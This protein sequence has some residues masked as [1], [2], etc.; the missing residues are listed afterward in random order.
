[1]RGFLKVV[2]AS[3][4][5]LVSSKIQASGL[6]LE[7]VK[8]GTANIEGCRWAEGAEEPLDVSLYY[9]VPAMNN[10]VTHPDIV[11]FQDYFGPL[12]GQ[13]TI[14]V[15]SAGGFDTIIV[16]EMS[17]RWKYWLVF[18]PYA[19][20]DGSME[21]PVFRVSN[22]KEGGWERPY[23]FGYRYI[24]SI[25]VFDTVWIEDPITIY[26]QTKSNIG[27]INPDTIWDED[28]ILELSDEMADGHNA[29]P[30][31]L[32]DEQTQKLYTIFLWAD[33][34]ARNNLLLAHWSADG[35]DWNTSDT[36]RVAKNRSNLIDSWSAWNFLSPTI[37][38][39]DMNSYY[40]WF[41]DKV[42]AGMGTQMVRFTI[43]ELGETYTEADTCI[44]PAPFSDKQLW[45]IKVRKSP[46]DGLYYLLA[47]INR[48][49]FTTVDSAGQYL[50]TSLDGLIWELYDEVIPRGEANT[51]DHY[52]YRSTWLF[53]TDEPSDRWPTWYTGIM[54]NSF[55]QYVWRIGYTT[56]NNNRVPGDANSDCHT[57]IL[58]A[59]F[60]IN[61]LY[62]GG[63]LPQPYGAGDINGDCKENLLDVSYL[64]YYLYRGGPIPRISLCPGE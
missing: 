24:D 4:F 9:G 51:W 14:G 36:I 11:Y 54:R 58:D 2:F 33:S 15:N 28:L 30:E 13:A 22:Q 26:P 62:K 18:T 5:I 42:Y 57:N 29:D 8:S 23:A 12:A 60:I 21:N 31:L 34:D 37:C 53:E 64:L 56:I 46:H 27:L 3:G 39:N 6:E 38:K 32:F 20:S 19:F 10:Q 40:L 1:M 55:Y 35:I 59:S 25:P 16:D 63:M 7:I 50:Y 49:N 44:I 48:K 47:T 52:T 45:H 61:Y 17:P 43:S 41:V